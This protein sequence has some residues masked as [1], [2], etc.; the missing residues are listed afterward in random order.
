MAIGDIAAALTDSVQLTNNGGAASICHVGGSIYAVVSI[1]IAGVG[2]L[3]TVIISN[4][5][6]ITPWGQETI[7]VGM[8]TNGPATTIIHIG[9]GIVAIF[10]GGTDGDG[11]VTTMSINANGTIVG[12]V[13]TYEFDGTDCY[14]RGADV[15][16]VTG[17]YYIIAYQGPSAHLYIRVLSISS[18]GVTISTTDTETRAVSQNKGIALWEVGPQVYAILIQQLVND[19]T[20]YTYS[21][22]GAGALTVVDSQQVDDANSGYQ[23][24]VAKLRD[25]MYCIFML[26]VTGGNANVM[27][28][29][30]ITSAGV[31][32]AAYTDLLWFG[33]ND[34]VAGVMYLGN[35]KVLRLYSGGTI[36]SYTVTVD[37]DIDAEY[38]TLTL[39]ATSLYT[40]F[41]RV[42]NTNFIAMVREYTVADDLYVETLE[43]DMLRLFP[44]DSITR[45]TN[46]IHR[47]N[48][49][50]QVYTME[51]SLGEV[52][53]DFGLPEW[54]SKP[55]VA[56]P[57]EVDKPATK[58]DVKPP[59]ID[60]F[61]IPIPA[62]PPEPGLEWL[63]PPPTAPK[64]P[65][66][67]SEKVTVQEFM[68]QGMV[69][70]PE[71]R[72]APSKTRKPSILG[73]A[74]DLWNWLFGGNK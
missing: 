43:V 45:I 58:G 52:T 38:D 61:S 22:S 49:A 50:E 74:G 46:I 41:V 27:E 37:G 14:W 53:S 16:R 2:T 62:A 71:T 21:V 11:F 6:I 54:L 47:Y 31:I 51:C 35:D 59:L 10:Y 5:G 56:I 32:A 19:S 67:P 26:G 3:Y 24:N 15:I 4:A 36:K 63:I 20:I 73:I 18:D 7:A 13:A 69:Q 39:S 29:W 64:P 1:S 65:T 57:S 9:G 44:S 42:G 60:P 33:G 28:T 55:M 12:V 68:G 40:D 17:D 25:G 70:L 23:P 66:I 48:R 72:E 8:A 34:Q 30:A